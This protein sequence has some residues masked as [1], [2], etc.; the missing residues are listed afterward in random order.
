MLGAVSRRQGGPPGRQHLGHGPQR[1]GQ[2]AGEG[3]PG[4]RGQPQIA[5][6]E[7]VAEGQGPVVA[8]EP[9]QRLGPLQVRQGVGRAEVERS[10]GPQHGGLAGGQTQAFGPLQQLGEQ[11]GL[12]PGGSQGGVGQ[13][14]GG[15]GDLAVAQQQM[16]GG[17]RRVGAGQHGGQAIV[18]GPPLGAGEVGGQGLADDRDQG[19]GSGEQPP[20]PGR[21]LGR[22]GRH[23]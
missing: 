16:A 17:G 7:P 4:G 9:R 21:P 22:V 18:T 10:Q 20:G 12:A 6:V 8:V 5:E 3:S 23:R 1:G 2:G 14:G 13:D 11:L 19:A 15:V